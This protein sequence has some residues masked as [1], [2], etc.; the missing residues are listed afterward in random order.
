MASQTVA[1]GSLPEVIEPGY[2]IDFVSG[3]AVKA[4]PE[5]IHATQVISKRLVEELGYEKAQI[6]T[7]PQFRVKESPSGAERWPVDVCVFRDAN[8]R[9]Y[10]DAYILVECKRPSRRDG[11]RQLMLYLQNSFATLGVWFNGKEHLYLRKLVLSSGEVRFIEL[12]SLPRFG[13]SV[14]DLGKLRKKDLK[15]PANLKAT[16]NDLRNHLAGMATGTTQDIDF[17]KQ[18]MNILFCKIWDEQDKAP[19][20]FVD[21]HADYEEAPDSVKRR[22]NAIFET[23][24]KADRFSGVFDEEDRLTLDAKSVAYIVGEIQVY[25]LTSADRDALS[26]AFE[27]FIGKTLKGPEGQFFTPRNVIKMMVEILDPEPGKYI[28]DPACGS[29]GFLIASLEH[30]WAKLELEAKRKNWSDQQLGQEKAKVAQRFF[31]GCDKDR[32]LTKVTKA[33]MA[34]VGDGQGGIVCENSLMPYGQMAPPARQA[35]RPGSYDF[36]LTNPPFGSKIKVEGREILGQFDLGHQWK[37]DARTHSWTRLAGLVAQRPPQILFIERCLDLLRVG[38]RMA[39][40]L[41][42]RYVLAFLRDRVRFIGL[43][44]LPEDLFQPYTHAKACVVFLEKLAPGSRQADRPMFMGIVK[45]CGHDSRGNPIPHDD[46]PEVAQHYRRLMGD[47]DI[48]PERFGFL[49][50]ST[51]ITDSIYIPKYYDP[52]IRADLAALADTHELVQ[53]G[54][55]VEQGVLASISTGHEVGKLAYGTGDIP[56]IRTSDL[57]NWELKIDPSKRFAPA[58]FS[59]FG[60]V[61]TWLGPPRC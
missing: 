47:P 46:V 11:E 56:F 23:K 43:V 5:E 3:R 55:L 48:R 22:I 24:V 38:G 30:V 1:D 37:V 57:A 31:R 33:Y 60:T 39:I 49:I 16:F 58:I 20:E 42:D 61:R 27:T 18:L 13:E 36:V 26:D 34:I 52:E 14:S 6:Q 35:L 53:V 10:E 41:P 21:F 28:I 51:Q 45:W 40:V 8:H 59:W 17:A 12:Y 50:G 29:G 15:R 32:F 7:H 4:G 2:I 54:H 19:D 44:S 9:A 25:S